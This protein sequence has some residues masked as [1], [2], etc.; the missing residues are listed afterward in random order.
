ML[1]TVWNYL[2][3]IPSSYWLHFAEFLGSGVVVTTVVQAI[4]HYTGISGE[5]KLLQFI[6]GA[7]SVLGAFSFIHL[8]GITPSAGQFGTIATAIAA[9]SAVAYRFATNPL[10]LKLLNKYEKQLSE[11]PVAVP[12]APVE[13]GADFSA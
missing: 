9:A 13:G 4:K 7:T 5:K 10:Y 6:N 2:I 3:N 12:V 11:T 1:L 8:S